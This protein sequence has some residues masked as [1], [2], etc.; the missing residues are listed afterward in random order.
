MKLAMQRDM[1]HCI[2]LVKR[3]TCSDYIWDV[4]LH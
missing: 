2:K 3:L 1:A 4:F